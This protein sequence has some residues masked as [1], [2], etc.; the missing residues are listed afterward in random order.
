MQTLVMPALWRLRQE[1]LQVGGLY[2]HAVVTLSQ[3]KTNKS[4]NAK[5]LLEM[6]KKENN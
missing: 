4:K 6:K 5:M 3:N 2:A 1:G